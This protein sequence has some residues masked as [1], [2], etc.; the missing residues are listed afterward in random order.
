MA[1]LDTNCLLRW[2]LDDIPE[3]SRRV[4]D[5]LSSGI[6]VVVSD[7]ALIEMSHALRHFY[8]A[9]VTTVNNSIYT[10]MA[11]PSVSMNR[12]LWTAI[13]TDRATHPKLSIVDL[14]LAHHARTTHEE[15]PVYTF[16]RKLANQIEDATLLQ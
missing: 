6:T 15:L 13:L 10:V 5:L 1:S 11:H 9:D 8:N 7:I 14:Y 3:Q 12:P 2:L 4:N 16:D